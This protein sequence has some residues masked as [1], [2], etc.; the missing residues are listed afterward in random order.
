MIRG[1][2]DEGWKISEELEARK[3][4]LPGDEPLRHMFNRGWFLLHQGKYQEGC[5]HLEAG[6]FLSVYGNG[7]LNSNKPIWD[8]KQNLQGK[9]VILN[10]EAGVGDQIISAR[11]ATD[12]ANRGGRCIICSHPTL[13]GILKRIPGCY[14]CITIN[15][16][17]ST[18]HD[19]WIPGFSAGWLMGY[20]FDSLPREPYIT[21]QEGSIKVWQEMLKC[22]NRKPKIGIRW[23]GNPKFEHQQ[24][25]KFPPQK[26]I[27]LSQLDQFQ[28]YSLQRDTD[29]YELPEN[30]IDLQHFLISWEDTAACLYNLDLVITSCTSI[31]HIA[32]A[33][34]LPVWVIVP[35][36]PY[37]IWAY[38][39]DHSPWYQN[40]TKVYRQKIFGEWDDVFARVQDD[41]IEKFRNQ[42]ETAMPVPEFE[43]PTEIPDIPVPEIQAI[44]NKRAVDDSQ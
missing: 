38:G 26:L 39:D 42:P 1:R 4:S 29:L 20:D 3:N 11:F 5:Q 24:F 31:A 17:H 10:L 6:R 41:I 7:K 37:H 27:D 18:Q 36:L 13:F 12:I 32:G 22:K 34:G 23:S 8:G 28:F 9:T 2:F 25:R 15:E 16:V 30:V 40:T 44:L 14:D 33:M 19:F 43:P 21:A 35:I